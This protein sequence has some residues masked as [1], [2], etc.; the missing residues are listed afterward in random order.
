MDVKTAFSNGT[1]KTK[2]YIYLP[3]NYKTV[4]GKVYR[5]GKL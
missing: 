2:I 5:L 3:G 4:K 1:V